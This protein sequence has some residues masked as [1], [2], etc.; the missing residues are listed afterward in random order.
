[1]ISAD[2]LTRHQSMIRNINVHNDIHVVWYRVHW[3][4]ST[5]SHS[6]NVCRYV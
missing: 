3:N 1:M 6:A 2:S 5:H 4:T